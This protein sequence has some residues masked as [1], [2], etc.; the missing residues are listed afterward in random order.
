MCPSASGAPLAQRR[1]WRWR[2]GRVVCKIC[3]GLHWKVLQ[4][5]GCHS[6]AGGAPW[7]RPHIIQPLLLDLNMP[8]FDGWRSRLAGTEGERRRGDVEQT[9]LKSPGNRNAPAKGRGQ[10]R[11]S[12][13]VKAARTMFQRH[14]IQRR[15]AHHTSSAPPCWG[16]P[17]E[18]LLGQ[19]YHSVGCQLT[20]A[21]V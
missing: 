14:T 20:H 3:T 15:S 6:R 2:L 10:T 17:G 21:L 7:S 1:R 12:R 13:H 9:F 8:V 11:V 16:L 4:S 5:W 18:T 19:W